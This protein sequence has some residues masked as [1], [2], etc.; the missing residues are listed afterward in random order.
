[1]LKMNSI[2]TVGNRNKYGANREPHRVRL[3]AV[4]NDLP[5]ASGIVLGALISRYHCNTP[6]LHYPN[7]PS[8][9]TA[10]VAST[11]TIGISLA[12]LLVFAIQLRGSNITQID[13]SFLR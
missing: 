9:R 12:H 11:S 2:A 1:M 4:S 3:G 7:A 8:D 5:S 10:P 13:N 6:P